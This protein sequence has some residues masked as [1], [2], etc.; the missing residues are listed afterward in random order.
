MLYL[1][2]VLLSQNPVWPDTA[3]LPLRYM[4]NASGSSPQV[5]NLNPIIWM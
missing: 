1:Q 5:Q 4:F 2:T 3:A